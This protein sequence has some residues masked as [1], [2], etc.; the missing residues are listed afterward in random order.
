MSN[1][2]GLSDRGVAMIRELVLETSRTAFKTFLHT[3]HDR[4]IDYAQKPTEGDQGFEFLHAR[5]QIS[6]RHNEILRFFC[7]LWMKLLIA[8][9]SRSRRVA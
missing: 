4:L 2:H 8:L 3:V 9:P 1:W 7:A 6:A 5:S